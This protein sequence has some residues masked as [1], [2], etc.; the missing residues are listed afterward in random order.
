MKDE[1]VN[2]KGHYL[3]VTAERQVWVGGNAAHLKGLQGIVE[4]FPRV[5]FSLK[6]A[7]S[8]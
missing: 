2:G 5:R 6:A 3:P 1:Y 8:W 7:Y 4:K